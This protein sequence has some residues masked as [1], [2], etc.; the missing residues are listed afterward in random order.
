MAFLD[1]TVVNVALPTIGKDLHTSLAEL[2]YLGSYPAAGEH[3]AAIRRDA[4]ERWRAADAWVGGLRG[5]MGS[6]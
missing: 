6:R 2:K 5:W 3:G 4:E 1:A